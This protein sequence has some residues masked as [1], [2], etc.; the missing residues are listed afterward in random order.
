M[1]I[2][3][4]CKMISLFRMCCAKN[5]SSANLSSTM[6]KNS[7]SVAFSN[8]FLVKKGPL[9]ANYKWYLKKYIVRRCLQGHL[10]II[11]LEVFGEKCASSTLKYH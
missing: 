7:N 6:I 10:A 11:I 5:F 8:D 3:W 9:L 1:S 4:V 2:N